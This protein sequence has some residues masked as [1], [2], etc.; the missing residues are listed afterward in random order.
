MYEVLHLQ[1]EIH[2]CHEFKS[3]DETIELVSL[4]QFYEEAPE[5]ITKPVCCTLG[6][7]FYFILTRNFI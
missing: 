2:K 3:R 6:F 5:E 7:F 1:K 4:E